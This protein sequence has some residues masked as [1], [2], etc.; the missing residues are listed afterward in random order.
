MTVFFFEVSWPST[1]IFLGR[2]NATRKSQVEKLWG[3][4]YQFLQAFKGCICW[5]SQKCMKEYCSVSSGGLFCFWISTKL[6][7]AMASRCV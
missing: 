7:E 6:F 2:L 5:L 1:G 3:S 4:L